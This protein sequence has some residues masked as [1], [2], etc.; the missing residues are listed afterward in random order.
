MANGMCREYY[1]AFRT[2]SGGPAMTSLK[3]F[4]GYFVYAEKDSMDGIATKAHCAWC[5]KVK[6]LEKWVDLQESVN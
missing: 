5:A 1:K 6:G 3:R 4:T 2:T